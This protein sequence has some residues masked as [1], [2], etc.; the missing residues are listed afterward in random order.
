MDWCC[1]SNWCGGGPTRVVPMAPSPVDER[2][3]A[4]GVFLGEFETESSDGPV[5]ACDT[6]STRL[7]QEP[8]GGW[9]RSVDEQIPGSVTRVERPGTPRPGMRQRVSLDVERITWISRTL[10][11]ERSDARRVLEY[12]ESAIEDSH[13]DYPIGAQPNL[14]IG[15]YHY[16]P[17][18]VRDSEDGSNIVIL[19]RGGGDS[20]ALGGWKAVHLGVDVGERKAYACKTKRLPAMR[21]RASL[22]VEAGYDLQEQS[23]AVSEGVAKICFRTQDYVIEE[24]GDYA[25]DST[26][27]AV[28]FLG[29]S[30]LVWELARWFAATVGDLHAF[31]VVNGDIKPGNILCNGVEDTFML[32]DFDT[33]EWIGKP[34]NF[35]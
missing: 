28:R 11:L 32:T 16:R 18:H 7:V 19:V 29:N 24:W 34:A 25:L 15:Q 12:W 9:T 27:A 10:Q 13:T 1:C 30:D 35:R 22:M 3:A 4:V 8:Y 33:G 6:V 17:L 5:S 26:R 21:R 2:P 20:V 23:R 14:E 31:G